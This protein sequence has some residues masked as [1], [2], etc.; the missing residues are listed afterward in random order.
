MAVSLVIRVILD[1]V[2][3]DYQ[4]GVP[5]DRIS[6]GWL[7]IVSGWLRV[8]ANEPADWRPGLEARGIEHRCAAGLASKATAATANSL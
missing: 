7:W 1:S 2:R 3:A 5:P 6:A 8:A 4:P